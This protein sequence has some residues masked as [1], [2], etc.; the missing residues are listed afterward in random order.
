MLSRGFGEPWQPSDGETKE[1]PSEEGIMVTWQI[2]GSLLVF[3]VLAVLWM[4]VTVASDG[5][6]NDPLGD[7]DY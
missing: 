1:P 6:V 5:M 3:P 4:L 2:L 7:P